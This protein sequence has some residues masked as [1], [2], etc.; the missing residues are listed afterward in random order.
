LQV[1]FRRPAFC[2]AQGGA[3][4]VPSPQGEGPHGV[5][6]VRLSAAPAGAY[7]SGWSLAFQPA[8]SHWTLPWAE[9]VLSL[10]EG[11]KGCRSVRRPN[12]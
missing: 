7:P 5:R 1:L 6:G 3:F 9:P 12:G 4:G 8:S 10:V 11:S 2:P